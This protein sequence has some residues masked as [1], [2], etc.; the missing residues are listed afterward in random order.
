MH[1]MSPATR[2]S[3]VR[4]FNI[5]GKRYWFFLLSAIVIVPG[6]VSLVL[7]GLNPSPDFVGGSE[8]E[9]QVAKSGQ[10]TQLASLLASST[11]I[12]AL[13][14]GTILAIGPGGTRLVVR[15]S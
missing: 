15:A 4:L 14:A 11:K 9:V 7:Y 1:P 5:I 6:F 12:P 2:L 10:T 8:I 13:P 3:E